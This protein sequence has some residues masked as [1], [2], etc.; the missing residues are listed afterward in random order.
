MS[1]TL[2]CGSFV[3]YRRRHCPTAVLAT[4][5][6]TLPHLVK[7]AAGPRDEYGAMQPAAIA[8]AVRYVVTRS[9][10]VAVNEIL[11]RPTEQIR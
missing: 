4:T 3:C 1:M 11:V 10:G 2:R 9:R 6:A 8:D 5:H 7:A